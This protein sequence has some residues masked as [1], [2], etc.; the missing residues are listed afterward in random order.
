MKTRTRNGEP[1]TPM[2]K[3]ARALL[4]KRRRET[5]AMLE[6]CGVDPR[7]IPMDAYMSREGTRVRLERFV[8]HPETGNV[9][10]SVAEMRDRRTEFVIEPKV[11]PQW[12]P[13]N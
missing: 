8:R 6:S 4:E 12:I 9:I 11:I 7:D 2:G 1:R 13:S 5:V 10:F 3:A